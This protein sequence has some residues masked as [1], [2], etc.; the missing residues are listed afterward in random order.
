MAMPNLWPWVPVLVIGA[1]AAVNGVM[2]LVA[3]RAAPRLVEPTPYLASRNED[4]RQGARF[5]FA[6]A[7]LRLETSPVA[8]GIAVRIRGATVPAGVLRIEHPADPAKD[9]DQ[10][11]T[12]GAT[13]AVIAAAPGRWIVAWTAADGRLAA[14][15]PTEA[16]P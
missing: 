9:R 1:A 7:G 12:A 11:W 2:F 14:R 10:P 13:A 4:A 5:A 16:G 15:I 3:R 6:D 8:G